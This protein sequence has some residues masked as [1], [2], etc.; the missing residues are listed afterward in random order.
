MDYF[1]LS[2][3][4]E[5]DFSEILMAELAEIG[6]DSFIG[7]CLWLSPT[8]GGLFVSTLHISVQGSAPEPYEIVFTPDEA[9]PRLSCSCPAGSNQMLCKHR[10]A[11]FLGDISAVTGGDVGQLVQAL[12]I[13]SLAN[14][15]K[16]VIAAEQSVEKAKRALKAEQKKFGRLL[17]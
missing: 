2:L 3:S 12:A 8:K 16:D 1:E 13:S 14:A 4:V 6:F 10:E 11:L 5:P 17:G 15:Y 7:R 9:A